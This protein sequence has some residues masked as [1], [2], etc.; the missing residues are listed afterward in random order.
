M[1]LVALV[2]SVAAQTWGWRRL[3]RRVQTGRLTRRSASLRFG[4]WALAPLLMFI[5]FMLG[6]VGLEEWSGASLLSEGVGRATLPVA[7]ALLGIAAIGW[8][9]FATRC[10]LSRPG[11]KTERGFGGRGP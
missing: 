7:A 8:I 1:L 5:A 10:A 9:A 3:W 6:A 4:I 11:P 2:V